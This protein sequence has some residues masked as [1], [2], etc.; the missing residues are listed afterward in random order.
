MIERFRENEGAPKRRLVR[1]Q[2]AHLKVVAPGGPRWRDAVVG[3]GPEAV[4]AVVRRAADQGDERF[5]DSIRGTKQGVNECKTDAA[6]LMIGAHAE[7]AEGQLHRRRGPHA[8]N[9]VCNGR[10]A[11]RLT[12]DSEGGA[13]DRG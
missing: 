2:R 1:G 4:P 5:A 13:S 6:T 8:W 10:P 11:V 9:H 7:R 3:A 12:S